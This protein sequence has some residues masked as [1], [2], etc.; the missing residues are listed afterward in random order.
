MQRLTGFGNRSLYQG[1]LLS[2]GNF[3]GVHRGHQVIIRHLL[4]VARRQA[5]PAV[6]LTFEPHPLSL[7]N[8]ALEPTRLTTPED[9]AKLLGLLG[10]DVVLEYPTDWD[11]LNLTPRQFFDD[12]VL[13]ELEARGLVEGPNFFFGKGRA[14]NVQTL[15]EFCTAA[16]RSLTIVPPRTVDG[17]IISSS[18]IRKL[19]AGGDVKWA[20]KLLGRRY[21]LVGKVTAGAQ[22]G[23][24]LGFP[25]ANLTNI[26]TQ[27]PAPG[28]YAAWCR[29]NG[30][31]HPAA[32]SLGPN[33]T[34]AEGEWKVE[35]HLLGFSG[36]L[37]ESTAELEFVERVREL[38]SFASEK[39]LK[40]QIQKDLK[41]I[42][43]LLDE[44][45]NSA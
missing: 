34:F 9:R 23:R 13:G 21:A 25:T 35:A 36:D 10:A 6:V 44:T 42:R 18:R 1:C 31:T 16:N 7:L 3:D 17:E 41:T 28:V 27:L 5:A 29:V 15:A 8:P 4:E 32:V 43:R 39:E 30:A 22:R 40:D 33:P 24:T 2:I 38:C 19:L 12:I 45:A 26:R 14:G 20:G 11:L 37:Y